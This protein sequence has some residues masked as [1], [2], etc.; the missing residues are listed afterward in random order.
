MLSGDALTERIIGLAIEV[1]R[2]SG[3]C[4]LET[5]YEQCHCFE[6]AQAGI[7][8]QRQAP[9]T[10]IYKTMQVDTAFRADILVA[11][12]VIVELKTVEH[13][14]PVHKAQLLTYLR[15]ADKRLGL[16]INFNAALIKDGITRI[17]NGLEEESLAKPQGRQEKR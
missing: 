16:L 13:L 17:V 10:A 8:H 9:L 5:A 7:P 3:P 2:H 11:D 12:E 1:H 14:S 15:L 6:L 4:L